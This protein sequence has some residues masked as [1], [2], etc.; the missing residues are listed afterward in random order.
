MPAGVLSS[1]AAKALRAKVNALCR[2]LGA[3]NGR[4]AL[5][6]CDGFGIPDHLLRVGG[7]GAG[8]GAPACLQSGFW[9]SRACRASSSCQEPCPAGVAPGSVWAQAP[10]AVGDWRSFQ[11]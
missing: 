8:C 1:A 7:A 11:G 2:Q 10:I 4:L 9:C 6:L 3:D 5:A